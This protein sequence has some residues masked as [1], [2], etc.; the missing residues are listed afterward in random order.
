MAKTGIINCNCKSEYQDE[1][2]G[3]NKRLANLKGDTKNTND[4]ARC[5]V[6]GKDAKII[7]RT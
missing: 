5:T 1:K 7:N 6:C 4:M 2:Y 3:K